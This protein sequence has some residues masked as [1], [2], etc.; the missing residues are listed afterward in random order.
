MD[1]FTI[2]RKAY[3]WTLEAKLFMCLSG[4]CFGISGSYKLNYEF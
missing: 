4:F 3:T 1:P 2:Q